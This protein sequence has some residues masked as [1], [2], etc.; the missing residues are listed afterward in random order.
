MTALAGVSA[1]P[2]CLP[3][4]TRGWVCLAAPSWATPARRK[5][6]RLRRRLRRPCPG[7]G[8]PAPGGVV[9]AGQ[10]PGGQLMASNVQGVIYLLH[11]DRPYR[12]A[13]HY[14]GWVHSPT[15]LQP[16]LGAHRDGVGARLM[17]VIGEAGIGFQLAR[18]WNGDRYRERALKRQGGASR[19]C[20]ICRQQR[21]R[22]R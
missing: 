9:Q 22:R 20:P 18:T 19:R 11:F 4:L 13:S 1:A 21:R 12:H 16:R 7:P 15:F 3:V 2:L 14:T 5:G 17:A 10:Q 6:S 8:S